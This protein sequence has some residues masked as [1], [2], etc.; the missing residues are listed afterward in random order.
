M[1]VVIS[2]ISLYLLIKMPITFIP[3]EI[4]R[5]LMHFPSSIGA[6][7]FISIKAALITKCKR[8][9]GHRLLVRV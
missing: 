2:D 4:T 3:E 6:L 9:R 7:L 8:L 1:H 5:T